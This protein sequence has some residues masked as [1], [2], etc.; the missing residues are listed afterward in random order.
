MLNIKKLL[1]L[2]TFII[3]FQLS[4]YI[5]VAS[6]EC[7]YKV[8]GK[9]ASILDNCFIKT[10]EVNPLKITFNECKN[11]EIRSY[12]FAENDNGPIYDKYPRRLIPG[13]IIEKNIVIYNDNSKG[14]SSF[15]PITYIPS[16]TCD[17]QRDKYKPHIK[18]YPHEYFKEQLPTSEP[19]KNRSPKWISN[20]ESFEINETLTLNLSKFFIDEDNDTL[21]F[22]SSKPDNIQITIENEFIEMIPGYPFNGDKTI[23]FTATDGKSKPVDKKISLVVLKKPEPETNL[24]KWIKLKL[25]SLSKY[26]KWLLLPIFLFIVYIIYA[27]LRWRIPIKNSI[28][29]I[30]KKQ[31]KNFEENVKKSGIPKK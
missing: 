24:I 9:D 7:P 28:K 29:G 14:L 16:V 19:Q 21:V 26:W 18:V 10:S 20:T 5:T 27:R 23:I 11:I 4:I 22:S 1:K 30:I 8:D 3:V 6:S 25:L 12:E 2:I 17:N 15:L 31:V 13:S